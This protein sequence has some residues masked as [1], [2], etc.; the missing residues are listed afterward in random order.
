MPHEERTNCLVNHRNQYVRWAKGV[1]Y[2]LLLSCR[3]THVR[4][5][6]RCL[7]TRLREHYNNVQKSKDG[8]LANYSQECFN[9]EPLYDACTLLFRNAH[10]RIKCMRCVG[11]TSL[12]LTP[13][14]MDSFDGRSCACVCDVVRDVLRREVERIW[15][16]ERVS[17]H[18]YV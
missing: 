15:A 1:V 7:N 8:N 4:P 5:A 6:G 3:R 14:V 10:Q 18:L 13:K 9:C 17:L 12:S 11:T 2:K 16:C